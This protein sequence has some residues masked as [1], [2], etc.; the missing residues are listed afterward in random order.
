MCIVYACGWCGGSSSTSTG[1]YAFTD[2]Y[3][4]SVKKT[5]YKAHLLMR[6]NSQT[7][8]SSGSA[9]C[10]ADGSDMMDRCGA[11]FKALAACATADCVKDMGK[12]QNSA[13]H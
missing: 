13:S 6:K 5:A 9:E 8:Y 12:L 2:L 11:I 4:T 10:K 1:T 7:S 3:V